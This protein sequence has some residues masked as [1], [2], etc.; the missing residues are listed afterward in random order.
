MTVSVVTEDVRGPYLR[1]PKVSQQFF[2]LQL[3]VPVGRYGGRC[4]VL[5]QPL[6]ARC[7]RLSSCP[8]GC[9]G[10]NGL[11]LEISP[12]KLSSAIQRNGSMSWFSGPVYLLPVVV[13]H[14]KCAGI[15][16]N[17]RGRYRR[18][19]G[20][21]LNWERARPSIFLGGSL[22]QPVRSGWLTLKSACRRSSKRRRPCHPS[23]DSVW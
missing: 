15:Y 4:A 12:W 23:G 14:Q 20:S 16:H 11:Q 17:G 2:C 18:L 21:F 3:S 7:T 1:F 6:L 19:G 5:T 13:S 10:H 9:S 8:E 22:L